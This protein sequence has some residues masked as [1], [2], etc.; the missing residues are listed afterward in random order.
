[1]LKETTASD[2]FRRLNSYS[3][4]HRLYQGIKAFG[5]IIKSH[6]ILRYLDDVELPKAIEKQLNK[7]ELANR[8]TRSVAVG[9]PRGFNQA[10]KT[11]QEIAETCNRLIKKFI[12]CWNYMN[13]DNKL[14]SLE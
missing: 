2:I 8:F 13:L 11:E 3:K 14:A 6:F 5:Q 12:I 4:Q 9:D 1:M 10:E 7:V